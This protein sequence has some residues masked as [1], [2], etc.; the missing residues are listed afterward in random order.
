MRGLRE[1]VSQEFFC[2]RFHSHRAITY[3][4]CTALASA[5][6]KALLRLAKLVR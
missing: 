2:D 5:A 4:I 3:G 1:L 6:T